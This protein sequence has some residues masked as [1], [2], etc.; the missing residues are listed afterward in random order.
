MWLKV[1]GLQR[2][3]LEKNGSKGVACRTAH[4]SVAGWLKSWYL[5]YLWSCPCLVKRMV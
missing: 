3:G 4:V 2:C 5:L 1:K